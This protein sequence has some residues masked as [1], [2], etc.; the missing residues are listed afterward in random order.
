[1]NNGCLKI[2][3]C[4]L[5]GMG[6]TQLLAGTRYVNVSNPQPSAPFEDWA[7][8]ATNIQQAIEISLPGDE[9][10]VTNGI[11]A[12][13]GRVVAGLLMNRV[14]VD[15]AVTI[16]SVNGPQFTTIRGSQLLGQTNG[17]GAVRCVY[18][19][20]GAV[21]SG[22]TIIGGATSTNG[23]VF[24]DQSGG[25]VWCAFETAVVTNCWIVG[26]S[27]CVSGG[28]I[29]GGTVTHCRILSNVA[30]YGGGAADSSLTDCLLYN[31]SALHSGGAAK[32]CS[33][34]N[35]TLV[36]NSAGVFGGGHSHCS[37]LNC[38]VY[39]NTAADEPNF[40]SNSAIDY[41]CTTPEPNDFNG[42]NN[43]TN[44]PLFVGLST[45]DF[46]LK[47]ISPCINAGKN[48]SVGAGVD[49]DGQPRIRGTSVDLGCYEFQ[50][51]GPVALYQWLENF[52]LPSDGSAD[53]WDSDADGCKNWQEWVCGTIPTNHSSVLRLLSV[54]MEPGGVA[55]RWASTPSRNYL[56]E[57]SF[58][59]GD[60]ASFITLATNIP[61]GG[62]TT[63]FLDREATATG[64][65]FYRVGIQP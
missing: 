60:Y 23:D 26:N 39:Y 31:N 44:E 52:Y 46:H 61:G 45:Q 4:L 20:N 29:L 18:V 62:E 32:G 14:A 22:F 47:G 12:S 16:R 7:T 64:A 63:L 25:G 50:G 10:V 1:M 55:V 30:Q 42:G 56:L 19:T 13:G 65:A 59:P 54:A 58:M 5:L 24:I 15:K 34:R 38:I 36:Q 28:G 53:D 3:C 9:I 11:Y 41:C 40:D 17:A 35:C 21:L 6:T 2:T 37:L 33:V 43:I 57:R 49:L 8:A 48:H 51:L 27:A